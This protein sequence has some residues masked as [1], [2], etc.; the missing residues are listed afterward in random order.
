MAE[1]TSYG[2]IFK[3]TFLF[4]FVQVFRAAVAVIN[5]K[6]VAILIGPE[7]MGLIGVFNSTIQ[8]IQ[9]GA[10]LGINQS[11]V[12]DVAEANGTGNNDRVSRIIKVT[13]RRE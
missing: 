4:G 10:G 7:G 1:K 13:Y 8:M 11:A 2:T 9:T 3:T 6:L 5:N 12:R